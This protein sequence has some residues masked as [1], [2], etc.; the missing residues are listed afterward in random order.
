MIRI[1]TMKLLLLSM[2]VLLPASVHAQAEPATGT[3]V[4]AKVLHVSEERSAGFA[5]VERT[6]QEVTLEILS[7]PEAGK[8]I[9][10]ENGIVNNR[11]DMRLETGETVVLQVLTHA[12]GTKNYLLRETYRVTSLLL[13]TAFFFVLGF[14]LG[15]KKGVTSVFGLGVSVAILILFVVPQI[16]AGANPL[17]ISLI[18]S[19]MIAVSSIYLSHGFNRRTT[20]AL[21]STVL[22]L[23]LS[24]VLAML[25]VHFGK[26]HGMG[27]EESVFLQAG[28]LQDMNLR[29]LLLGGII[30]GALG[31]LDDITTAQTAAIDELSRANHK[32]GFKELYEAGTSIGGEHI[33]SLINTLAL[34]YVGASLPLL[35][36]FSMNDDMP[37]WVILNSEFVAEEI[38]RTLV[39]SCTLLLAVPISTWFAANAFANGNHTSARSCG[40]VH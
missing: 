7:G 14:V 24:T 3:Y 10:M 4:R 40:H 13:L 30:I 8:T 31:V 15:G 5:G 22:T 28:P 17:F 38:V 11:N 2:L 35:L 27:T 16:V 29:G 25:F 20:I 1:N 26:L 19:A 23:V 32:L 12:D 39:G 34:A 37:T 9:D 6:E 36:L 33:A 18:G 21:A